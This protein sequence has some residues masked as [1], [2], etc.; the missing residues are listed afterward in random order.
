MANI[1]KLQDQLK[2]LPD[3][4]L[5]QYAQ[6]PDGQV[7]Q[8]LILGELQRRKA[9]R[10]EFQQS[11]AQ[12][13]QSTVAEDLQTSA[14]PAAQE[15]EG[16]ASLPVPDTMFQEQSMAGGGIVA[17]DDG[18]EVERFQTGN[19]VAP[20]VGVDATKLANPFDIK[21]KSLAEFLEE[22]RS[23]YGDYGVSEAPFEEQRKSLEE[24][25]KADAETRAKAPWLALAEAGFRT[26]AGT[27]PFA[28]S[29][30]ATGGISGL[31]SYTDALK[32]LD[33]SGKEIRQSSFELVKAQDAM[34]RG[35]VKTAMDLASENLKT[36]Q[37]AGMREA[38]LLSA[39][40][41][42]RLDRESTEKREA[43]QQSGALE[44]TKI[45]ER[46]ANA[47]ASLPGAEERLINGVLADLKKK[48]PNAT[49]SDA[50]KAY[51]NT[52]KNTDL[53]LFEAWS[54]LDILSKKNY[55][56]FESY[57]QAYYSGAGIGGGTSSGVGKP[58]F[59]INAQG[60]IS[61]TR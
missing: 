14:Q 56:T 35:D 32:D 39:E 58:A 29:N 60:Q 33:K 12:A 6:N 27:S 47:R 41:Q 21:Q 5:V 43:M 34:K 45:Q 42:K 17:F 52:T 23:A 22:L 15:G 9:M 8:Y 61:A 18:G 49:I 2:G 13:P 31:K 54:K 24:Q 26:A 44:R 19:L 4:A 53:E 55:P 37:T 51:K 30:I 11:Q 57:V 7:P 38:E 46:G 16:V 3:N 28:L 59:T 25:K 36:V 10:D 20:P 48:D 1:L 50:I 40:E